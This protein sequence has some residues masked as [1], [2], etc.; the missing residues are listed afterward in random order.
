MKP[1]Q[2]HVGLQSKKP[3]DGFTRQPYFSGLHRRLSPLF[4]RREHDAKILA[5]KELLDL[6]ATASH[7][8][9][10]TVKA[11]LLH[12]LGALLVS[13]TACSRPGLVVPL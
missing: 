9:Q 10:T 7:L 6:V 12:M 4:E 5:A 8:L 3:R 1:C 13:L 2:K 11:A